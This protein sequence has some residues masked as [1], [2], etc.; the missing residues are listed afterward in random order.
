MRRRNTRAVA[1]VDAVPIEAIV[2]LAEFRAALRL[3]QRRSEEIA[4]RWA[5]TPQRYLMLLMIKGARDHRQT[6]NLTEL[7]ERL[8]LSRNAVTELATR[9]EE[10]GL[11]ERTVGDEDQRL[12]YLHLTAEGERRL[13]GAVLEG[14]TYRDELGRSFA[15]LTQAYRALS[16]GD[17]AGA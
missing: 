13:R 3:F 6:L 11:V 7:A 2:H 8:Q 16:R 1:P 12:V 4:R 5:L 15:E 14:Q 17:S 9:A 10:T